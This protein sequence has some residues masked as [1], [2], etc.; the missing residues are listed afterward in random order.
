VSGGRAARARRPPRTGRVRL[1][2]RLAGALAALAALG[3]CDIESVSQPAASAE[4]SA[5][6]ARCQLPGGPLGVC[7][8]IAC[9]EAAAPPCFQCTPQH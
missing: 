4:C 7:Q 5:I 8:E 6:G 3:A 2:R 1:A 9:E